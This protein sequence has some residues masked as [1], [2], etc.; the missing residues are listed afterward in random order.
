MAVR[1]AVFGLLLAGTAVSRST[2]AASRSVEAAARSARLDML[3][4]RREDILRELQELHGG[5]SEQVENALKSIP[6]CDH[7]CSMM[8][9]CGAFEQLDNG[10]CY[11][12]KRNHEGD[13]VARNQTCMVKRQDLAGSVAGYETTLGH[14]ID[15]MGASLLVVNSRVSQVRWP[16]WLNFGRIFSRKSTDARSQE[17]LEHVEPHHAPDLA[18]AG[19][20]V[21]AE[22]LCAHFCE[23]MRK[24]GAFQYGD[25][26]Q[27]FLYR[28]G[29]SG[30]GTSDKESC[31]VKQNTTEDGYGVVQGRCIGPD[32][33]SRLVV[34]ASLL[35]TS[36]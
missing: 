12:Y 6:R 33:Y 29:H 1:R 10:D 26:G 36:S 22:E 23:E 7:L 32:G 34:D 2:E 28:E 20:N 25:H 18:V 16:G 35:A 30:D 3:H 9:G 27:C 5:S 4:A 14:C 19:E 21:T 31:F 17:Q 8:K 24:C 11:F 13:E 15:Q